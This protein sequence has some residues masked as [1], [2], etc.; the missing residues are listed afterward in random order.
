MRV[1]TGVAG[2]TV[3]DVLGAKACAHLLL[4]ALAMLPGSSSGPDDTARIARVL[5]MCWTW[6]L[7]QAAC[8]VLRLEQRSLD[9][10]S[11]ETVAAAAAAGRP[12]EAA[13]LP[14]MQHDTLPDSDS[15]DTDATRPVP[16]VGLMQ[17]ISQW[18]LVVDELLFRG[19]LQPVALISSDKGS[20]LDLFDG[21]LWHF[22]F[23]CA[24]AN[25]PIG[26]SQQALAHAQSLMRA[27]CH[28]V[29]IAEADISR[30]AMPLPAAGAPTAVGVYRPAGSPPAQRTIRGNPLAD[31][32]LGPQPSAQQPEVEEP[33]AWEQQVFDD[34]YH[35]HT[36]VPIDPAYIGETHEANMLALYANANIYVM[37]KCPFLKDWQR[38]KLTDLIKRQSNPRLWSSDDAKERANRLTEAAREARGWLKTI[39]E[40]REQK[41]STFMRNYA[42]TLGKTEYHAPGSD[43]SNRGGSNGSS[44]PGARA[45][46]IREQN[47]ARILAEDQQRRNMAWAELHATLAKHAEKNHDC[48]DEDMCMYM[49]CELDRFL[50]D[51]KDDAASTQ[52]YVSASCFKLQGEQKAWQQL[53]RSRARR[54]AAPLDG[55]TSHDMSHAI[56]VWL[57]VQQLLASGLLK[58]TAA[59]GTSQEVLA[60]ADATN[61]AVKEALQQCKQA[62]QLLGFEQAAESIAGLQANFD[63]Q[64]AAQPSR[65][66]PASRNNS[67]PASRNNSRPASAAAGGSSNVVY[68]VG[69]AEAE[70]QLRHCGDKLHRGGQG[71]KDKRVKSFVPDTWQ[72]HVMDAI[73]R[74]ESCVICA[75]TSSGKTFISSFCM[76]RVMRESKDGIVVFVAPTKALVNQ[77]D[78][79]SGKQCLHHMHVCSVLDGT[80]AFFTWLRNTA[81]A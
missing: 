41:H 27:T 55:D 67:R 68:H 5:R 76:D 25:M 61:V 79:C 71:I 28:A 69:M 73:D 22:M 39:F 29:G 19:H 36:G 44:R 2:V 37:A 56:N 63:E 77:T 72:M 50:K 9:L 13:G 1:S 23:H 11:L 64:H 10:E 45:D 75:P 53:C 62:M 17:F 32:F 30:F 3:V 16:D 35:W 59:K 48:W 8:G 60:A 7:Q 4:Q 42:E 14:F 70:F 43:D 52:A 34:A 15:D 38:R 51:C 49:N 66:R 65:S 20:L 33:A 18:C 74:R 26:L 57:L 21:R 81:M 12:V 80:T 47:T 58:Y 46:M 6:C 54:S 31:A 78:S 40:R 24:S